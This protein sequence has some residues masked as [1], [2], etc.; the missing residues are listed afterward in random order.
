MNSL[1]TS[2]VFKRMDEIF[3]IKEKM[4]SPALID[5]YTIDYELYQNNIYNLKSSNFRLNKQI[6]KALELGEIKP[7]LCAE[8][9]EKGKHLNLELPAALPG[10]LLPIKGKIIGFSDV[11]FRGKYIRSATTGEIESF[12]IDE[13]SFYG[14]MQTAYV[15]RLLYINK[16]SLSVNIKFV[17]TVCEAYTHL[18]TR[19]I[20]AIYPVSANKADLEILKYITV[21]FCLQ[22]FFGYNVSKARSLA[23]TFTG[24]E[25]NVILSDCYYYSIEETDANSKLI[26]MS[27]DAF[28]TRKGEKDVLYPIDIY[29]NILKNEF[30]YIKSGKMSFRNI[31]DRYV[32]MYGACGSLAIEH[33]GSFINMMVS[34]FAKF[35]FYKDLAIEKSIGAYIDDLYKIFSTITM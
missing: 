30:T 7:I 5:L 21:V 33:C 28:L 26:N 10:F 34:A 24:I 14:L 22:N 32:T 23:F 18:L 6:A 31:L 1:V 11:S 27:S 19:C 2:S 13:R 8:A 17:R 9:R 4:Q 35:N 25:K 20:S 29:L 15:N 12:C 16:N 3:K